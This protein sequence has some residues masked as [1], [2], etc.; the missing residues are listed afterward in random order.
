MRIESGEF[1]LRGSFALKL[2]SEMKKFSLTWV[3]WE[4]KGGEKRFATFFFPRSLPSVLS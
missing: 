2:K 3:E 4:A 1:K